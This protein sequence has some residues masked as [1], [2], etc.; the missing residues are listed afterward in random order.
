[1]RHSW[2]PSPRSSER[3]GRERLDRTSAQYCRRAEAGSR[4]SPS[5]PV[6]QARATRLMTRAQRVSASAD[7]LG[8]SREQRVDKPW[9]AL[10]YDVQAVATVRSG[11]DADAGSPVR[12]AHDR[13]ASAGRPLSRRAGPVSRLPNGCG[14]AVRVLG[15]SSM[16]AKHHG[17]GAVA[18]GAR[19]EGA[20][21]RPRLPTS[22]ARAAARVERLRRRASG[23]PAGPAPGPTR[24]GSAAWRRARS[25]QWR[26]RAR[27]QGCDR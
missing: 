8:L 11:H 6:R 18:A 3:N 12:G 5:P 2:P 27:S 20:E 19:R 9:V 7:A 13:D 1:M 16:I 10:A 24:S 25:P 26:C 4:P 21:L 15:R 22:R 17:R 14:A 23:P